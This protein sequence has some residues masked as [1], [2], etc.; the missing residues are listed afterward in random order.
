MEDA[1]TIFQLLNE[2][3]LYDAYQEHYYKQ[4][5]ANAL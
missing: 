2:N 3:A 4:V 1:L 5:S